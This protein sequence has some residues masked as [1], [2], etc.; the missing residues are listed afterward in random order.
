MD[1]LLGVTVPPGSIT[2]HSEVGIRRSV[3]WLLL[4]HRGRHRSACTRP[5]LQ[6][7][8]WNRGDVSPHYTLDSEPRCY[9]GRQGLHSCPRDLLGCAG[10]ARK[11]YHCPL[12][13]SVPPAWGS[14]PPY[15][16]SSQV[17]DWRARRCP[18]QSR[19]R[20]QSPPSQVCAR[21]QSHLPGARR[22]SGLCPPSH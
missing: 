8:V 11:V 6:I 21:Q 2:F 9:T 4:S 18:Q 3:T 15:F 10:H 14:R 12:N 20:T 5:S 13:L 7:W 17:S 22:R 19:P 1:T 16:L